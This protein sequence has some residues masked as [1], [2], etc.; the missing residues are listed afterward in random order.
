MYDIHIG[1]ITCYFLFLE[2]QMKKKFVVEKT[3]IDHC[4]TNLIWIKHARHSE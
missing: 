2:Q 3:E 1:I 4:E